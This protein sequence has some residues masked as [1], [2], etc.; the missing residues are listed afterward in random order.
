MFRSSCH[1]NQNRENTLATLPHTSISVHTASYIYR[2]ITHTCAT[3]WIQ[4]MNSYFAQFNCP[5]H[6]LWSA[7]LA[8]IPLIPIRLIYMILIILMSLPSHKVVYGFRHFTVL[9][10]T[11][12]SHFSCTRMSCCVSGHDKQSFRTACTG[13]EQVTRGQILYCRTS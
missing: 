4:I 12:P 9:F 11:Q 7:I 13:S 3:S 6:F 8:D 5:C 1:Y 2:K 10:E